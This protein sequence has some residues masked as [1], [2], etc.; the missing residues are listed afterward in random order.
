M[1]HAADLFVWIFLRVRNIV[2]VLIWRSVAYKNN[3]ILTRIR[4][5]GGLDRSVWHFESS[6]F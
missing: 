4:Q 3:Q 2:F 6:V 1:S 5:Q